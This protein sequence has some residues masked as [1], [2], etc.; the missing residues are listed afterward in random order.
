[1]VATKRLIPTTKK[2]SSKIAGMIKNKTKEYSTLSIN[3][4]II[5]GIAVRIRLIPLIPIPEMT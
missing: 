4:I 1:M 5:N 3:A 2:V